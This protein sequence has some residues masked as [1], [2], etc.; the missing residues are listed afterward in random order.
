[1]SLALCDLDE[2]KGRNGHSKAIGWK[3][4]LDGAHEMGALRA[5][6]RKMIQA[7]GYLEMNFV[8]L[9]EGM[10]RFDALLGFLF[11]QGFELIALY[12]I[13]YLKERA[14]WTDGLFINSRGPGD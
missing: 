10:P 3:C 1:M 12:R 7:T 8:R 2:T 9:Y 5:A 11:D 4:G 13:R 6:F 14:G